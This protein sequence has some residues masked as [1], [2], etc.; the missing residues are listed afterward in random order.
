MRVEFA[1]E[2]SHHH[3]RP[4]NDQSHYDDCRPASDAQLAA[5]DEAA[6]QVMVLADRIATNR[7]L[8]ANEITSMLA[9][10]PHQ[11]FGA[12]LTSN[13]TRELKAHDID[14]NYGLSLAELKAAMRTFCGFAAD[15]PATHSPL[16]AISS[17]AHARTTI[18]EPPKNDRPPA[19]STP[20][21]SMA[22]A[23]RRRAREAARAAAAPSP[24]GAAAYEGATR[25]AT[26][27]V[28][29]P[30]LPLVP[31]AVRTEPLM[32]RL[33]C[34]P[35]DLGVGVDGHASLVHFHPHNR[36]IDTLFALKEAIAQAIVSRAAASETDA[37]SPATA[38]LP[39]PLALT[40]ARAATALPLFSAPSP[41]R[42][43][44]RNVPSSSRMKM[45][46]SSSA[47]SLPSASSSTRRRSASPS[48]RLSTAALSTSTA[49]AARSTLDLAGL[50]KPVDMKSLF[51]KDTVGKAPDHTPEFSAMMEKAR[52][53]AE[54]RERAAAKAALFD[55]L[56]EHDRCDV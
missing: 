32:P 21:A 38:L 33:S 30:S 44:D 29:L 35:R 49:A 56:D 23:E 26:A 51:T 12:W 43:L 19:R 50:T 8:T 52:A 7:E 22:I 4:R 28:V 55:D 31:G 34:T 48:K 16:G 41:R 13:H 10:T 15:D 40:R 9:G 45:A 24:G 1:P 27:S 6:R 17:S 11:A 2:D 54:E 47:P 39:Q 36:L 14:H 53:A 3:P 42:R 25:A 46:G 20:N 37:S 5:A 18:S